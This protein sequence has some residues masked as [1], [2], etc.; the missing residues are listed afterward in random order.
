MSAHFPRTRIFQN[1]CP[2]ATGIRRANISANKA[3]GLRPAEPEARS[4]EGEGSGSPARKRKEAATSA[5]SITT[6]TV[7]K[8]KNIQAVILLSSALPA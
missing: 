3:Y 2:I 7:R 8:R 4:C 1:N 5:L 6:R